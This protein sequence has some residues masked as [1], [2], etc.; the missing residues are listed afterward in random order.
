MSVQPICLFP[1]G[2]FHETVFY[3]GAGNKVYLN[4]YYHIQ[5]KKTAIAEFPTDKNNDD[6]YRPGV[7]PYA[8]AEEENQ[9][10]DPKDFDSIVKWIKI[11]T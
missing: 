10:T 9:A 4:N 11:T 3:F 1:V 8:H 6:T 7:R 5:L 2:H